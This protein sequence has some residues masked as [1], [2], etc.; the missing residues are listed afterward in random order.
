MPDRSCA[1]ME[2]VRESVG[3]REL[4]EQEKTEGGRGVGEAECGVHRALYLQKN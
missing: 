4:V 3:C 1:S 2:L